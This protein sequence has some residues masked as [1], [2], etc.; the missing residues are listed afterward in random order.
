MNRVRALKT[1]HNVVPSLEQ[2]PSGL[3]K[4]EQPEPL[5]SHL[6]IQQRGQ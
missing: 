6:K 2:I 1:L 5:L 4:K 3:D